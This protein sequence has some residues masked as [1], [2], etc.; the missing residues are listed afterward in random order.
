MPEGGDDNIRRFPNKAARFRDSA[1]FDRKGKNAKEVS[2]ADKAEK[3][4]DT[5]P[6]TEAECVAIA[7]EIVKDL[8]P[9]ALSHPSW[10]ISKELIEEK[11]ALHIAEANNEAP[12]LAH[13]LEEAAVRD[14]SQNKADVLLY[15]SAARAYLDL[16]ELRER[17]EAE[18][19]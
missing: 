10:D 9:L 6:L 4:A 18:D 15:V 8:T 16:I 14:V 3:Q 7:N 5:E 19:L 17:D 2:P 11:V 13:Y 12:N 1:G